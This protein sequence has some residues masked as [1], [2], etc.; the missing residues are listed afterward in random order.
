M[1]DVAGMAEKEM[2][3]EIEDRKVA[4]FDEFVLMR[5]WTKQQ[6]KLT[7]YSEPQD[8]LKAAAQII[9]ARA[10]AWV[11]AHSVSK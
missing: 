9:K 10:L 1:R 4:A 3:Q 8:V 2:R 11:D 7:G 6:F 5:G